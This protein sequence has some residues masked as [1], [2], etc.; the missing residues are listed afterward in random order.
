[1]QQLKNIILNTFLASNKTYF[2]YIL[3]CNMTHHQNY[4][5]MYFAYMKI[6]FIIAIKTL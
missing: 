4:M 1:M 6:V 2:W 5:Y 3:A